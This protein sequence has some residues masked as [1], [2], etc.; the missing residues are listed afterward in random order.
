MRLRRRDVGGSAP[1]ARRGCRGCPS[2]TWMCCGIPTSCIPAC[3]GWESNGGAAATADRQCP[4]RRRRLA[5][6]THWMQSAEPISF[7]DWARLL[8]FKANHRKVIIAD[9]GRDGL[10][11]VVGS[12]NPHDASSAHSKRGPQVTGPATL[13][14]LHSELEVAA[15]PAGRVTWPPRALHLPPAS[16]GNT[17]ATNEGRYGR[18]HSHGAARQAG[19]HA[20]RREYRHRHVLCADRAVIESLL[21]ASAVA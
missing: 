20:T 3:G 7:G 4:R 12:A 5:P 14:L 18:R 21:A 11:T 13:P 8:N 1:A 15:S 9:D 16:T 19:C 10:V 6:E 17:T 2:P